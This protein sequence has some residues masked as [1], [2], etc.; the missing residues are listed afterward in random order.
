MSNKLVFHSPWVDDG[1]VGIIM[2]L[3]LGKVASHVRFGAPIVFEELQED[4]M[5]GDCVHI[6]GIPP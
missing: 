3:G 2:L 5:V 4:E 6:F 1:N